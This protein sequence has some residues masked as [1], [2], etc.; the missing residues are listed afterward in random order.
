MAERLA[1]G[2]IPGVGWRAREIQAVA[3]EAEDAGFDA[4]FAAEVN[5]DV[6]ATAQLMGAALSDRLLDA[7]CLIGP[8]ARCRE[9]LAA[10]RSAGTDL[11]ILMPSVDVN[12]ARALIKAFAR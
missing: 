12:G 5:N 11:P 6:M 10:F 9:Q 4:V 2:I 8:L 7:V 1:L 3:R